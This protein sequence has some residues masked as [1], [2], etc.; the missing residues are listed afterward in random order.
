MT[1]FYLPILKAKAGEFT[2]LSKLNF[3]IKSWVFPTF[4]ITQTEYD[5]ETNS[6]A[7]TLEAHLVKLTKKISKCWPYDHSFV[8]VDL[9]KDEVVGGQTPFE[10]IYDLLAKD[11]VIPIPMAR[12]NMPVRLLTGLSNIR[13]KYS[14]KSIGIRV[15]IE[16]IDSPEFESDL[17]SLLISLSINASECHMIFDLMD[18]DFSETENFSDGIVGIIERFPLRDGWKS[19]TLAGGAFPVTS[20]LKEGEQKIDR[21]DWKLYQAVVTKLGAIGIQ[22]SINFGDYS[23]VAPGH[24]AYDP[25]RMQTSANIRYTHNSTWLVI[26]GKSLKTTGFNQYFGISQSIKNS[27]CFFGQHYSEGDGHLFKCSTGNT[28]TGNPQVW[29]WVGNNHHI[30][31][32]VNDLFSNASGS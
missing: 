12:L 13:Q 5:N 21:G 29:K 7:T 1:K 6:T 27:D 28:G 11:S 18:S 10:F 19:F 2:A 25:I 8:D 20:K 4:E 3:S 32:V 24:F 30:T 31:K 23:I 17:E 9:I 15:T 14:I 16:D 22:I 26:K